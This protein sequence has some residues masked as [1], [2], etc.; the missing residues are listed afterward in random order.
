M[1]VSNDLTIKS[2]ILDFSSLSDYP[3]KGL[4]IKP[5]AS[6]KEKNKWSLGI[7]PSGRSLHVSAGK[8]G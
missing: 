4:I 7:L 5:N 6:K 3:A 2:L 1:I 8:K